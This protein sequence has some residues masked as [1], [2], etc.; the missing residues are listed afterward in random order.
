MEDLIYVRKLTFEFDD[1]YRISIIIPD[2]FLGDNH[3]P[4][5]IK[6]ITVSSLL[7]IPK[8]YE[9]VVIHQEHKMKDRNNVTIKQGDYLIDPNDSNVDYYI[10]D[11]F[12]I[13]EL[14]GQD[15]PTFLSG[16]MV[17]KLE[18]NLERRR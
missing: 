6:G 18:I 8:K 14:N 11:E 12:T 2:V 16:E 5:N 1:E 9:R 3:Q 13:T 10:T 4:T 7:E 15:Y 17:K